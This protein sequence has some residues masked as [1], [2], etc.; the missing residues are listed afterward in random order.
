M[1]IHD[2]SNFDFF[3]FCYISQCMFGE[4]KWCLVPSYE[5][6]VILIR[7]YEANTITKG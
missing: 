4:E 1:S 6:A 7:T 2:K 3:E 5:Y